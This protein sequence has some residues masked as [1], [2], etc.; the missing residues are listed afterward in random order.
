MLLHASIMGDQ[1]KLPEKMVDPHDLTKRCRSSLVFITKAALASQGIEFGSLSDEKVLAWWKNSWHPMEEVAEFLNILK[2]QNR[3]PEER[4][5]Y[6]CS[7]YRQ[8][9]EGIFN[10]VKDQCDSA[11]YLRI[12]PTEIWSF[13]RCSPSHPPRE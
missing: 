5:S 12:L 7:I 10:F 3:K 1:E 2:D 11:R 9:Y 8:A 4:A 13:Q 6:A